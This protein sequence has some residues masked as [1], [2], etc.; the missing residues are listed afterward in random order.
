MWFPTQGYKRCKLCE[1]FENDIWK[2]IY[3]ALLLTVT[4]PVFYSYL[5]HVCCSFDCIALS[6]SNLLFFQFILVS[7][8]YCK[9]LWATSLAWK[10]LHKVYYYYQYYY[11]IWVCIYLQNYYVL[12]C[13]LPKTIV[14]RKVNLTEVEKN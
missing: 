14:F 4:L 3:S 11:T 9:A 10:V 2:P 12:Q 5:V 13:T 8:F 6:P 7:S 1:N